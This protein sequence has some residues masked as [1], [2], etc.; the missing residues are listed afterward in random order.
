VRGRRVQAGAVTGRS[1]A[2]SIISRSGWEPIA[3]NAVLKQIPSVLRTKQRQFHDAPYNDFVRCDGCIV[4]LLSSH[5]CARATNAYAPKR[6][7][8][9]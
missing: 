1:R 8:S 4:I 7:V 3:V 9:R 6:A 2:V 5:F